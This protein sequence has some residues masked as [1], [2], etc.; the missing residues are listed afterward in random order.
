[1]SEL[2]ESFYRNKNEW[3]STT[4]PYPFYNPRTFYQNDLGLLMSLGYSKY[5]AA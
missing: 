1:M 3:S 2:I 4:F 5:L